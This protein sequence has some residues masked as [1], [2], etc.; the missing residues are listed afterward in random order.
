MNE[1]LKEGRSSKRKPQ[2]T[3]ETSFETLNEE[4]KQE[5][6]K[7]MIIRKVFELIEDQEAVI[8]FQEAVK[9]WF[10]DP[11]TIEDLMEAKLEKTRIYESFEKWKSLTIDWTGFDLY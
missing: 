7:Q 8:E 11:F 9:R 5:S 1:E 4:F 2:F 3:A 6:Q 10:D